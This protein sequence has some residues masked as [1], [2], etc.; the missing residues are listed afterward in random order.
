[1]RTKRH[2]WSEGDV[3]R[4]ISGI[5]GGRRLTAPTGAATRPTS[6]RV[7]EGIFSRL[8]H[9]GVLGDAIVLD[10]YAGS[11][12]L[13]LEA[14]SRG[15]VSAMLV[16]RDRNAVGAAR[17][18]V[19][20]LGW[21]HRVVVRADTVERTLMAGPAGERAT[22][23]FLDPPYDVPSEHVDDVLALLVSH[24]WLAPDAVVVLERSSRSRP[25]VW[26]GGWEEAGD[27]RYGETQVWWA[28]VPPDDDA[29]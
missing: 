25:P 19:A 13:G 8:E 26:P 5:A 1:M 20:E 22:V 4:I 15:A 2:T 10:L 7:R 28:T 3:T 23:V 29:A 9:F 14:V 16:E 18:N 6:D 27:R 12:A 17:R 24:C 21:A 11:G